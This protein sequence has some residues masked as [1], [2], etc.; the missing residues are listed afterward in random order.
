[1]VVVHEHHADA[2]GGAGNILA[3]E[4]GRSSSAATPSG[5]E[6]A[7]TVVGTGYPLI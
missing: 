4:D 3:V 1:M 6:I 7:G 2:D 5:L